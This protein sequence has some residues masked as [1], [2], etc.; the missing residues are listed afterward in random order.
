M[1]NRRSTTPTRALATTVARTLSVLSLLCAT[2]AIASA[3]NGT[4]NGKVTRADNGTGLTG[5]F[6]R[7]CSTASQCT[8]P[9]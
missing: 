3:Q 5:G 2:P 1:I 9:P 8:T 6:V 7:F 4:V